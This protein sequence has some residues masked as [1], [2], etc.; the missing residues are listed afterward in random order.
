[1]RLGFPVRSLGIVVLWAGAVVPAAAGTVYGR[2]ELPPAPERGPVIA[3]GFLDR[4]E[5][6]LA[7][8]KKPN[9]AP[10]FVVA[11][12]SEARSAVAPPEVKWDVVGESFS[13]PVVAVPVGAEVVIRN[14][15]RTAWTIGAAEDPKLI[16]G[17]L[18]PQGSKSFRAT[19]PAIY[20]IG[21]KDV[22]HLKGKIVVVATPYVAWLDDNGR[23]E[24]PGVADGSYKLRVFYYDPAGEAHG[25]KSEWLAFTTDVNVVSRGKANRTEVTAK[26]PAVGLSSGSAGKK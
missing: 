4:V 3:K 22:P 2:L 9:I 20:T 5:N 23:F 25:K 11:L 1:M 19:E 16:V 18:N 24:I 10:Y 14:R 7:E 21:D 26:L 8:I 15:T 12:E 6:P 13:R 17:P